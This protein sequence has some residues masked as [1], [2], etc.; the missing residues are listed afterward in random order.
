MWGLATILMNRIPDKKHL[1]SLAVRISIAGSLT[2]LLIS[3][4]VGI[5]VDSITLILDASA[6][7]VILLVALLMNFSLKKIHREPDDLYNFGY[8]KFEPLTVLVQGSLIIAT[9]IITIKFAIQ[10]IVHADTVRTYLLP[11][12]A[13]FF[14]GLIGIAITIRIRRLGTLTNSHMI[15]TAGLHWM[16]DTALSFGMCAGFF[17]GLLLHRMGD[18]TITPYVDPIMAILLAIF[19]IQAPLR[20]ISHNILE[21]LD[22]C[23]SEELRNKVRQVVENYRPRISSVHRIRARKAG[24]KIFVDVGFNVGSNMTIAQS[25][26]LTVDFEKDLRKELPHC[27]VVVYYKPS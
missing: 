8:T 18:T 3:A 17:L 23:P 12:I 16:S 21:L 25:E 10:D 7:V 2:L 14:C 13:T 22:A 24:E 26:A 1:Q 5:M 11:T 6:S 15:K 20:G 19:F 9:C 27:D 4:T